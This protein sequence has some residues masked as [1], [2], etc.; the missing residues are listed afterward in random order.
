MQTASIQCVVYRA[1]I[2]NSDANLDLE[3]KTK[4]IIRQSGADP[5]LHA[6]GRSSTIRAVPSTKQI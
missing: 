5:M 2:C 6:M 4:K 1:F 3:K